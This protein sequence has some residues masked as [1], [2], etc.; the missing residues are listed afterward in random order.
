[1]KWLQNVRASY[2]FLPTISAILAVGLAQI[3]QYIDHNE[4]LLTD[5]WRTT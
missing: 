5:A 3:T 4:L 1:M 2:R